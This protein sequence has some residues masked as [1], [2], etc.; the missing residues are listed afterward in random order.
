MSPKT[1]KQSVSSD[2]RLMSLDLL[3]VSTHQSKVPESS[4][5]IAIKC[6]SRIMTLKNHCAA[7][8]NCYAAFFAMCAVAQLRSLEGTLFMIVADLEGGGEPAPTPPPFG[9]RTDAV[10]HGH[11][12]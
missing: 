12:S 8:G 7:V 10:T 9:R 6:I 3:P 4:G 11:V 2:T 5:L 1:T